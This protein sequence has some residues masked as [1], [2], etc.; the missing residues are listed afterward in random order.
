MKKLLFTMFVA[1]LMVGCGDDSE[2]VEPLEASQTPG[3]FMYGWMKEIFEEYKVD[4]EKGIL[5]AQQNLVWHYENGEG[6]PRD[7]V[8]AYAWYLVSAEKAEIDLNDAW[9]LTKTP[10][11]IIAEGKDLLAKKM[12]PE[13]ITKGQELSKELLKKIEANK[14]ADKR[15]DSSESKQTSVAPLETNQSSAETTEAKTAEGAKVVV[16][17]DD[18]ELRDG[19]F[20]F[21]GEPFTGV[22]VE[23]A[24]NGQKEWEATLKDG[25]KHGL[26]TEWYENGQ[27]EFEATFKDGESISYKE[28]DEDGNLLE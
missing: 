14:K 28:W 15:E 26:W 4:A 3:T 24:D 11:Q 7:Y 27:K 2:S 13:Q 8:A 25:K 12:T 20:Y 5:N 18:I 21:K 6:V 16:D 1:L 10:K 19:L 22:A 9:G 17:G 23:K